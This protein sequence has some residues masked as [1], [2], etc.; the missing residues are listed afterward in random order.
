MEEFGDSTT[1]PS[2]TMDDANNS[3]SCYGE[4]MN[5]IPTVAEYREAAGGYGTAFVVIGS[6]TTALLYLLFIQQSYFTFSHSHKVFR[7][8][9]YWL[10]SIYPLVTLMSTVS[11]VIPRAHQLCTAIKVVYMSIGAGHFAD[12]TLLMYGSENKMLYD[13]RDSKIQ[14]N[15]MPL[16]CF[17]PC[18][19]TPPISRLRVALLKWMIWQMKWTQALYYIMLYILTI[20]MQYSDGTVSQRSSFLWLTLLNFVSFLSGV[21]ALNI[22]GA[23]SNVKL[24]RFRYKAKCLAV[25][26]LILT[27]KMQGFVFDVLGL[28]GVFP[29]LGPMITPVV[30]QNSLENFIFLVEMIIFGLFSYF[31]YRLPEFRKWEEPVIPTIQ[32]KENQDLAV[33][34]VNQATE[35]NEQATK[36]D[37]GHNEATKTHRGSNEPSMT[38]FGSNGATKA[39]PRFN[40]QEN[41]YGDID[42]ASGQ[43]TGANGS[44]EMLV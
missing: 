32:A 1:S 40:E 10:I 20:S 19:P 15:L 22:M 25:K 28:L 9:I 16:C 3:T 24:L 42:G 14:L 30:Y 31:M 13:L 7:R 34:S 12:L 5:Y 43:R 2:P 37:P 35:L 21:Y 6:L 4:S 41:G 36:T 39:Y 27:I 11:V 33:A 8:H 38:D 18:L 26:L 29:C 17:F 44:F 23:L